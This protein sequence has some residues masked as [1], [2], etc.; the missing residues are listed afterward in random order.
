MLT[1]FVME[2]RRIRSMFTH[3]RRELKFSVDYLAVWGYPS[4]RLPLLRPRE[5]PQPN[6]SITSSR[7]CRLGCLHLPLFVCCLIGMMN[8]SV[9]IA[10]YCELCNCPCMYWSRNEDVMICCHCSHTVIWCVVSR[11]FVS[12]VSKRLVFDVNVVLH[13]VLTIL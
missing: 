3:T 9:G 7:S 5:M 13:G 11:L 1:C 12:V 8:V 10:I 6:C 2:L 4:M